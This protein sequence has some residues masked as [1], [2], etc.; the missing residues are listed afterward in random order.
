MG[1][2]FTLL[3]VRPVRRDSDTIRHGLIGCS[4]LERTGM[5]GAPNRY[6]NMDRDREDLDGFDGSPIIQPSLFVGG[7]LDAS[8]TI[9]T[10]GRRSPDVLPRVQDVQAGHR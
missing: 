3:R 10:P 1:A 8:T 5:S 6:R 2:T 9:S 7:A 4:E